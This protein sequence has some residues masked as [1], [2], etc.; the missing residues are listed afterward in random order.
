MGS[1]GVALTA[2]LPVATAVVTSSDQSSVRVKRLSVTESAWAV[3][4]WFAM[5][6]ASAKRFS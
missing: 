3:A 4:A 1:T 6:T 2:R 5:V